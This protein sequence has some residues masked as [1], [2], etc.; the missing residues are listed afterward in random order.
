MVVGSFFWLCDMDSSFYNT[1]R[2][3]PYLFTALLTV[4]SIYSLLS[5][6][7][8]A[9][10]VDSTLQFIGQHTITI[11]TFHF[12]AFKLISLII[13]RLHHLPVQQL[14]QFPVIDENSGG[15][16]WW[17]GYT[18][19]GIIIPLLPAMVVKWCRGTQNITN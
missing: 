7:S 10:W 11:L 17:I 1:Y 19:A 18:L 3:L 13:I 15:G 12:V 6:M 8:I 9:Q 2:L 16:W 14:S 5:Q 4:W